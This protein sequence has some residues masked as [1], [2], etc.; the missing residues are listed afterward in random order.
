[1]KNFLKTTLAVIVGTFI[2]MFISSMMFFG[3]IGGI[4]A[5]LKFQKTGFAIRVLM[6]AMSGRKIST[7]LTRIL[8]KL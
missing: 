3:I 6:K 5:G 2:A 1:M 4:A 7:S 8:K